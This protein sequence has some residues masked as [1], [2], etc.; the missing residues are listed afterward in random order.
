MNK[1]DEILANVKS[2]LAGLVNAD[3][4]ESVSK[5]SASI[6]E[7]ATNVK[8][9]TDENLALKDKIVD[10]VKNTVV[11]NKNEPPKDDNEQETPKD[12]DT[13]LQEE[14]NKIL[15]NNK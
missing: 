1:I 13:I 7:L 15:S 14:A 8:N 9:L 4:T 12:L 10:M 5:V 2:G 6:D 11:G 3:N